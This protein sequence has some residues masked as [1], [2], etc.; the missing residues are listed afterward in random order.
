M[1]TKLRPVQGLSHSS[2]KAQIPQYWV[3]S[4]DGEQRPGLRVKSSRGRC[5]QC[6]IGLACPHQSQGGIKSGGVTSDQ[7]GMRGHQPGPCRQA[8]SD[9][10][11]GAGPEAV[12]HFRF[13]LVS[14]VLGNWAPNIPATAPAKFQPGGGG[15]HI[16]ED[17]ATGGGSQLKGPG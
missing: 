7:Q 10:G 15:H 1:G 11:C 13:F 17:G 14:G 4:S 12:F 3:R 16:R 5:R 9:Q 6:V 8:S 2:G